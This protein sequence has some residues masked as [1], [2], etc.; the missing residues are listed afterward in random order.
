[1]RLCASGP[2]TDFEHG[3]HAGSCG[4]QPGRN[5]GDGDEQKQ[6]HVVC[7]GQTGEALGELGEEA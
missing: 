5:S 6:A 2:D 7:H 4:E 1:M 3:G